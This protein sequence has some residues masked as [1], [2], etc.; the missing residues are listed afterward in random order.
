MYYKHKPRLREI[1]GDS[2]PQDWHLTVFRCRKDTLVSTSLP[3]YLA[4]KM[5]TN[6]YSLRLAKLV[7]CMISLFNSLRKSIIF[8][9]KLLTCLHPRAGPAR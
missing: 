1:S 2:L 8:R 4:G 6:R 3:I 9:P 7:I 5:Q